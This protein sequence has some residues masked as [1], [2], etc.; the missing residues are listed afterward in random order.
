MLNS[1]HEQLL[2]IRRLSSSLLR[3]P[4]MDSPSVWDIHM[5]VW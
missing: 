5:T 3:A 4:I 2:V 1:D